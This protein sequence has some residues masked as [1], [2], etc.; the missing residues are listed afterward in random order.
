MQTNPQWQKAGQWLSGDWGNREAESR[1]GEGGISKGKNKLSGVMDTFTILIMV[2]A[3]QVNVYVI[4]YQ[5]K[6]FKIKYILFC[7]SYS[8]IIIKEDTALY[9]FL[10]CGGGLDHCGIQKELSLGWPLGF[11]TWI[12]I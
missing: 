6:L 11:T 4:T 10:Y 3:A 7:I 1:E 9:Y 8:S 5:T 2:M 12:H